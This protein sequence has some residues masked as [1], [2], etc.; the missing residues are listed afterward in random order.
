ML[1]LGKYIVRYQL[2]KNLLPSFAGKCPWITSQ[3]KRSKN[4]HKNVSFSV[5]A[6]AAISLHRY[7]CLFIHIEWD[8]LINRIVFTQTHLQAST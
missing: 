8:S 3:R 1:Y 4:G 6:W 5:K 7:Q 2:M